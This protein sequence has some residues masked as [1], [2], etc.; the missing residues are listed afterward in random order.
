MAHIIK[1]GYVQ[2]SNFLRGEGR[3]RAGDLTKVM[4]PF[5]Q[6]ANSLTRAHEGT[7]LGLPLARLLTERHE[8]TM[9]LLS[10][11]G[12]GTTVTILLPPSRIVEMLPVPEFKAA[13]Y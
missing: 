9:S 3:E 10:I 7:G 13:Q 1:S 12:K 8:G 5:G 6:V 4:E 2:V 11:P